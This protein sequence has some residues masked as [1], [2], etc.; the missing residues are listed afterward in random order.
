MYK[1]ELIKLFKITD[2]FQEIMNTK[3]IS[4]FR[5]FR[6]A[7]FGYAYKREQLCYNYKIC[8]YPRALLCSCYC[9]EI[10]SGQKRVLQTFRRELPEERQN[11]NRMDVTS[12]NG[13]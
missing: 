7:R 11:Q 6:Y 13:A 2:V 10:I 12:V 5:A 8:R 1:I 4:N 9:A 3:P